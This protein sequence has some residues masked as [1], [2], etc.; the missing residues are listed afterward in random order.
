MKR[1]S[2]YALVN[3]MVLTV[4]L[5]LGGCGTGERME[6]HA[7][8]PEERACVERMT[9]KLLEATPTTLAGHDQDWDAAIGSSYSVAVETCCSWRLYEYSY[10][11]GSKTGSFKE[12]QKR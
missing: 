2:K 8:T 7:E 6:R 4:A 9:T 10:T 11:T 1:S 5:F 3:C 12:V